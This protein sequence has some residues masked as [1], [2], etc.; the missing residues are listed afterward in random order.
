MQTE[1]L[2]ISQFCEAANCG[3]TRAYQ[4]INSGKIP[5]LKNG[6]KT[7]IRR[8]DVE[9]WI[10]SLNPYKPEQGEHDDE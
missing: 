1:L 3:R 4:L 6:K 9:A 8:A 5:A 7:L 10:A 2:T